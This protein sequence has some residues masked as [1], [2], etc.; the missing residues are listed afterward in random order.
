MKPFHKFSGLIFDFNGVLFW[1][2]HL[3]RKSWLKFAGQLREAPLTDG[4]IDRRWGVRKCTQH[5]Y[6]PPT[7]LF[8]K[9]QLSQYEGVNQVIESLSEIRVDSLFT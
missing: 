5:T 7:P 6:E 9:I 2:D 4:E 8:E 1:D 3:Q